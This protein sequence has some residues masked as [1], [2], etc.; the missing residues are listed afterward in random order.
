MPGKRR[1]RRR[2][3]LPSVVASESQLCLGADLQQL[4]EI[5]CDKRIECTEIISLLQTPPSWRVTE[6]L[7]TEIFNLMQLAAAAGPLVPEELLTFAAKPLRN[8]DRI[9]PGA[10]PASRKKA[11]RRVLRVFTKLK[12][13]PKPLGPVR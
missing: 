10:N 1:R 8:P 11:L 5:V 4:T 3:A 7:N 9:R 2:A 6:W 13:C 12:R